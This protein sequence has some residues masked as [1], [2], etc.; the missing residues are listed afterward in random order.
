M[1]RVG[2]VG[3]DGLGNGVEAFSVGKEGYLETIFVEGR[4]VGR[5]D[6]VKSVQ[7]QHKGRIL[8]AVI[9]RVGWLLGGDGAAFR[10]M[11]AFAFAVAFDIVEVG[12]RNQ[13]GDIRQHN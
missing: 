2:R 9:V 5:K 6:G 13:R 1:F 8:I 4:G 10:M 3:N 7:A 11:R 12:C